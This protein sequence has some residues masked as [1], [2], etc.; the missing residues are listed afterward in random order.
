[1]P[2]SL[3]E[4][5]FYSKFL[6]NFEYIGGKFTFFFFFY[7][8]ILGKKQIIFTFNHAFLCVSWFFLFVFRVTKIMQWVNCPTFHKRTRNKSKCIN[9]SL[10]VLCIF[11]GSLKAINETNERLK[12]KCKVTLCQWI[13]LLKCES[14]TAFIIGMYRI[15]HPLV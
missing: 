10:T 4:F 7:L 1:M 13:Q 3:L 11:N 9:L 6:K 8:L 5:K 12:L 2:K 14:E 15:I